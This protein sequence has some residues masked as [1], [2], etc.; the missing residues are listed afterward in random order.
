M[1]R[2][3]HHKKRTI[4]AFTVDQ[5][6]R[7]MAVS[8]GSTAGGITKRFYAS[9]RIDCPDSTPKSILFYEQGSRPEEQGWYFGLNLTIKFVATGLIAYCCVSKSI[10]LCE[11]KHTV[12]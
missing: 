6:A 9:N 5:P 7:Q 4:I 3:T 10:L 8:V 12:V 1:L 11:Q 2:I